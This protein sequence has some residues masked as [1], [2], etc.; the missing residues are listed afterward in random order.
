MRAA[1]A[2]ITAITA[3]GAQPQVIDKFLTGGFTLTGV[4]PGPRD[5]LAVRSAL[6]ISGGSFSITP[7]RVI[8][9]R[10]TDDDLMLLETW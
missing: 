6:A 9:R 5:L 10:E 8:L 4:Q 7:D 3:T 2:E 1:T